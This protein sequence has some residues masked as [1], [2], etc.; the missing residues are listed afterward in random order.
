MTKQEEIKRTI[1]EY[2]RPNL[3]Y[4]D[5]SLIDGV[6]YILLDKLHSQGVVIKVKCPDC[7]WSQFQDETVGMTPCYR[8]NSPG[9]I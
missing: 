5:E 3:K 2:L 9:Y 4:E 1:K 7:K 8:C 6:V